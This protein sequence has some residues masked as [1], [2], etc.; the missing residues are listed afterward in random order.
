MGRV[1]SPL[2]LWGPVYFFVSLGVIAFEAELYLFRLPLKNFDYL[3]MIHNPA[4]NLEKLKIVGVL[5][6][7]EIVT[8]S[9]G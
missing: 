6:S 4:S 2:F 1:R 8:Q 3:H 5:C 7:P 9:R